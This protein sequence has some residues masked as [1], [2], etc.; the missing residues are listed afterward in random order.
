MAGAPQPPHSGGARTAADVER[1]AVGSIPLS[2]RLP[3]RP[4]AWGV[5]LTANITKSDR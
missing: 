1:M 2:S 3:I 5:R 4:R